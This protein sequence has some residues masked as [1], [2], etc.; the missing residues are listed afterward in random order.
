MP[1]TPCVVV[2]A[3]APAPAAAGHVQRLAEGARCA[4]YQRAGGHLGGGA[5]PGLGGL[6]RLD[7]AG[8]GPAWPAKVELPRCWH[9]LPW[10]RWWPGCPGQPS[11]CCRWPWRMPHASCSRTS[12]AACKARPSTPCCSA[13]F[14]P[15][16]G[17]QACCRP[18]RCWA[19]WWCRLPWRSAPMWWHA[20][21][22]SNWHCAGPNQS[23]AARQR[24][25]GPVCNQV[26][27]ARVG[28]VVARANVL[29]ARTAAPL[30]AAPA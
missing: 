16:C 14:A 21:W 22:P 11:C 19:A 28:A 2:T 23:V 18:T 13:P 8:P 6:A 1:A 29:A 7:G 25:A 12:T 27:N 20:A 5:G 30:P 17:L 24:L 10:C 15:R 9:H 26:R 4:R 3:S